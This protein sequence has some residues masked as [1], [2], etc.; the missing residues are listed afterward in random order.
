VPARPSPDTARASANSD[1]LIGAPLGRAIRE[2]RTQKKLS[3]R[4]LASAAEISQ[5]FLS[6]IES[7]AA[8]PSLITLYRIAKVLG[9]S[10]SALLPAEPEL[11]PIH[12]S[13]RDQAH[14]VPIAEVENA[15]TTRVV[16]S[17]VASMQEYLIEPGQYMGDWYE[18][19]GEVTVYVVDGEMTV[20]VEN[21]GSWDLGPGD[22]LTYPGA[23]RNRWTA[24]GD[25]RVRIIL[26][27]TTDT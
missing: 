1:A 10:P 6:Q 2:A 5:P 25:Q 22:A 12:L 19:D 27:Y 17:G 24:R 7:G 4:A 3:M 26:A 21:R 9:L 23:L 15:G 11:E 16:H 18:S 8:M 20:D 13:R 14:W